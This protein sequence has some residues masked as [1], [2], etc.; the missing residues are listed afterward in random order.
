[1]SSLGTLFSIES[2]KFGLLGPLFNES[3]DWKGYESAEV[4]PK[5]ARELKGSLAEIF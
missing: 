3:N 1:L 2:T 5:L 4:S